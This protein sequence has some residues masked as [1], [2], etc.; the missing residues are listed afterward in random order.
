MDTAPIPAHAHI[1]PGEINVFWV[2]SFLAIAVLLGMSA[3]ISGSEVAFFSLRQSDLDRYRNSNQSAEKAIRKLLSNPHLLLA[4]ILILNNLVNLSVVTISTFLMWDMAATRRPTETI[5]GIVTLL[6]TF[7]IT[8]FGEVI[9]KFYASR[10][11]WG[12]AHRLA[13]A[14]LLADSILSPISWPMMRLSRFVEKR[15]RRKGYS[16]TVD[17]LHQA[18]ELTVSQQSSE[19]ERGILKGIVNFGTLTVKQVMRPRM[20]I[21]AIDIEANF[22]ELLEQINK[23]RFSRCPVYRE[24]IDHVEGILYIKDLLPHLDRGADFNWRI[25]LRPVFFVPEIKKLDIL[26][27][28]FQTKHVHL[29]LV[30]DEYGGTSGLIT[31]EDLL[32]E[33]VGDINDEFDEVHLT[34]QKVDNQNFIFEGKTSIHEMC[35]ALA[36]PSDY[37]DEVKG[38]NESAGGLMLELNH[39]LPKQGEVISFG[40][41]LFTMLS[42]DSVR[43]L[44]VKVTIQ[45]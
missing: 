38:E 43:I 29:A 6:T 10:H 14:W 33:I 24:T 1:V 4:N 17:E 22:H 39:I 15:V 36:I 16:S 19:Q 25:L 18:L 35:K 34:Y 23:L 27:K 42:V 12:W 28:D 26:L 44:R 11:Y 41:F 30:V 37:F 8:F 5:V 7:C 3:V 32:E 21:S 13:S 20:D 2:F 40:K 31:L 45:N 9:P